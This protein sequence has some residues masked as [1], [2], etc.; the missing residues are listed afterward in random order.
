MVGRFRAR[1]FDASITLSGWLA[2]CPRPPAPRLSLCVFMTLCVPFFSL[3][4]L[5]VGLSFSPS[6]LPTPAQC[7]PPRCPSRHTATRRSPAQHA[8]CPEARTD[9][10]CPLL[11]SSGYPEDGHTT[12]VFPTRK[13]LNGNGP[14]D[15]T[16]I[17]QRRRIDTKHQLTRCFCPPLSPRSRPCCRCT[18]I[19]VEPGAFG[20]APCTSSTPGRW[21]RRSCPST[22]CRRSSGFP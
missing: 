1:G 4:C 10:V 3:W 9:F 5:S 19:S 14:T 12:H 6:V 2:G 13:T 16:N 20:Q 8:A 22:A 7:P 15:D 17:C 11:Y 18:F 21:G